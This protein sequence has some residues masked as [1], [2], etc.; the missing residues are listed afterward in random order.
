MSL[1]APSFA[2][3]P[4][5]MYTLV[6]FAAFWTT[7][8]FNYYLLTFL[9]KYIP[10]D[11]FVNTA[12]SCSS[13]I[14]ANLTSGFVVKA[15]GIKPSFLFA[16]VV[17]TAGGL[18]MTFSFSSD[19]AM[20]VFV[21][22]SK[23]GIAFAFNTAY[24]TTPMVFPI[25]L[26]STAFGVCNVIARFSTIASPLIAEVDPP[27]PFMAFSLTAILG[28]VCALLVPSKKQESGKEKI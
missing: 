21:L 20:A 6:L 15:I 25:I 10:G 12:V 27:V 19:S 13:E 18:L 8:S 24:L 3:Q 16:Y 2:N 26:T 28:I 14:V 4:G 11:I 22:L 5:L 1:E 7:S 23:F 17:A 9:L